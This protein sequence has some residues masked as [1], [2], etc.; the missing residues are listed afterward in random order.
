MEV[1]PEEM[2]GTRHI[3]LYMFAHDSVCRPFFSGYTSIHW[4]IITVIPYFH[5]SS[6]MPHV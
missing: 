2:D 5:N 6:T 3:M 4:K 1:Y